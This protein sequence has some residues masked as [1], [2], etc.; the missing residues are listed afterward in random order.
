[1]LSLILIRHGQTDWNQEGRIQGRTDI[2]LNTAGRAQALSLQAACRW[3]TAPESMPYRVLSSPLS[4][5]LE[6]ARIALGEAISITTDERLAEIDYGAWGGVPGSTLEENQPAA[7]ARWF[8]RQEP[9]YC[10]HGGES[11]AELEERA[12]AFHRAA[13]APLI[14]H[15]RSRLLIFSHGAF[16][17]QYL[18]LLLGARAI[19]STRNAS[20][21]EVVLDPNRP[22][23]LH[24]FNY[25][26]D[27][28]RH[29]FWE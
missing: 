5:A 2:P 25:T 22:P 27:A 3:L 18:N 7:C 23:R 14:A 15:D 24:V 19:F 4:R 28:S 20:I 16:I 10:P 17:S 1:M 21:S 29:P 12:A 9:H 6:T 8:G 11:W 13:A 26:P